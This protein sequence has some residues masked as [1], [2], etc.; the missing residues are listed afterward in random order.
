MNAESLPGE[1]ESDLLVLQTRMQI[2]MNATIKLGEHKA[3]TEIMG[4]ISQLIA[5]KDMAGDEIAVQVLNWLW[6]ELS[7]RCPID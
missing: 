4:V 7:E 1:L 2:L 3:R 6:V 5:E